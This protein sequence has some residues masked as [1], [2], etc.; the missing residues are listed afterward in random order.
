MRATDIPDFEGLTDLGRLQLAEELIA[1]IRDPDALPVP[2]AH[3]RELERRWAEYEKNPAS[4]LSE[5]DFWAQVQ[6]LS[7]F[8]TNT[9]R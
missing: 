5:N 8:S 2:V 6:S 3:R 4:V 9:A 7:Q 1:S